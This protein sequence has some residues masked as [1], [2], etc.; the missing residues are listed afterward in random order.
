LSTP[1]PGGASAAG[2]VFGA[3]GDPTR[4]HLVELLARDPGAATATALSSGLPISRQAVTKH[5]GVLADAR[6]VRR[7]RSGREARY[8][9]EPAAL[10]EAERWL[11]DVGAAWDRRLA[12]LTRVVEG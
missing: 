5:L 9:L 10:A 4:R 6:I 1:E 3:L 11:E 12:R 8:E 7:R 2:D